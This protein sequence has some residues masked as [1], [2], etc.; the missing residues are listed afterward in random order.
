[1][2]YRFKTSLLAGT[3]AAVLGMMI[4]APASAFDRV[5]WTWDSTVTDTI[6][7]NVTINQELTPTGLVQV[8]DLQVHIGDVT[9]ESI[10]TGI[11]NNQPA[12]EGGLV[13][14]GTMDIQFQYGLG[15]EGVEVLDNDFKSPEVLSATVD[16]GDE[17]PDINGTVFATIDLGE[18]EIE[19]EES[20]DALTEL[21]SVVSTATAVA[22]NTSITSDVAVS[23]HEGQFA[24]NTGEGAEGFDG[25]DTGNSNLSLATVLGILAINGGIG[26]G[27]VSA[28]S[29]VS[30]ILNA[31]VESSATAVV[32]N[33]SVDVAP[34]S[35]QDSVV[36]ADIVQFA[37]ANSVATS[38]VTDVSLNNYTSLGLIDGPVISSV[39]TAVGNN[40]SISV[41]TPVAIVIE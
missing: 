24:F 3:S 32:N 16:E 40:K 17:F 25:I 22:N 12:G 7:R 15:G 26:Q 21:P 10:V 18:I 9:A 13:D 20:Y 19:A 2:T 27:E 8:E 39:A 6:D 30:D 4:A 35:G 31:S 36:M 34:V 38:S 37:F 28:N 5:T 33:L 29:D 11:T 23:L 41:G 1:M 14:A